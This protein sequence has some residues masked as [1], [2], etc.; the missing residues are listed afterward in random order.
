MGQLKTNEFFEIY[1]NKR[2]LI[3]GTTQR[4][5][6]FTSMARIIAMVCLLIIVTGSCRT[7][8][9]LV[10]SPVTK[11]QFAVYISKMTKT[12]TTGTYEII[13]LRSNKAVMLFGKNEIGLPVIEATGTTAVDRFYT[14]IT[15]VSVSKK[16]KVRLRSSRNNKYICFNKRGRVILKGN[17]NGKSCV[18]TEI[19]EKKKGTI[20]LRSIFNNTWYVGFK[21]NGKSLSGNIHRHRFHR[22][23]YRFYKLSSTRNSLKWET[24]MVDTKKPFHNPNSLSYFSRLLYDS[25]N[26]FKL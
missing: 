22:D 13:N 21:R 25:N 7:L 6:C 2:K 18:F 5:H 19:P 15:F 20:Q 4:K 10:Y 16:N 3:I 8:L 12:I 1:H 23:C 11:D 24:L 26:D 9:A 17:G 14:K